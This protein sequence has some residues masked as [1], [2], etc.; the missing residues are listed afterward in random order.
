MCNRRILGGLFLILTLS[1]L[2][3]VA[4]NDKAKLFEAIKK[5]ELEGFKN[6]LES[7]INTTISK[8]ELSTLLYTAVENGQLN[9]VKYLVEKGANPNTKDWYQNTPFGWALYKK[10]T[11][12]VL[13]LIENGGA[14][15]NVENN[16]D[17]PP[18]IAARVGDLVALTA[19]L[20]KSVKGGINKKNYDGKSPI[21]MGVSTNNI[22]VV[23]YLLLKNA[24]ITVKDDD[25]N[26]LIHEF[27]KNISECSEFKE[28]PKILRLLLEKGVD[29]NEQNDDGD[30]ALHLLCRSD[31]SSVCFVNIL[32]SFVKN[33]L[34][35]NMRNKKGNAALHLIAENPGILKSFKKFAAR[36]LLELGADRNIKNANGKC[37]WELATT[38]T[39]RQLRKILKNGLSVATGSFEVVGAILKQSTN[40]NQQIEK[41]VEPKFKM[42]DWLRRQKEDRKLEKQLKFKKRLG[43]GFFDWRP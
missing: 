1:S 33:G 11:D 27:L 30:T 26:T 34:D 22:P 41:K 7:A 40:T 20:G 37:P 17:Y 25:K 4:T 5:G 15:V 14:N 43:S 6:L 8:F 36:R 12:I 23:E 18:H 29:I 21:F 3:V 2:S 19:I 32:E 31:V 24:N 42:V 38:P 9:I 10:K 39:S 13:W 16:G 28:T 35:L